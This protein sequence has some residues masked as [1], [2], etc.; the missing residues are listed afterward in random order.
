MSA[1]VIP[2]PMPPYSRSGASAWQILEDDGAVKLTVLPTYLVATTA[3][4]ATLADG[5]VRQQR[6]NIFIPADMLAT[7]GEWT[8]TGTF[9]GFGSM[10]FNGIAFAAE[11][12]WDGSGWQMIGGNAQQNA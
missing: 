3:K 2:S 7:T 10:N 11:L 8:V 9:A 6:K 12:E 4:T 5:T 1:P